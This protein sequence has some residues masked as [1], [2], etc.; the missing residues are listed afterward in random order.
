[1]CFEL[2][3]TFPFPK[4]GEVSNTPV[5]DVTVLILKYLKEDSIWS[6]M[7]YISTKLIKS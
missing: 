1:M 3:N 6:I 5:L 4:I 2:S 7:T